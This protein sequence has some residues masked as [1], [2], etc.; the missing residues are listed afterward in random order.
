MVTMELPSK[1]TLVGLWKRIRRIIRQPSDIGLALH[2]GW[3]MWRAP[4]LLRRRNLRTFL[5]ELRELRRPNAPDAQTSRERILRLRALC[6]RLPALRSRANCYIRALTLYRFL[7]TGD[8]PVTIHFGIEENPDPRERL[9]GHAW[10][11]IDGQFFEGPPEAQST[12]I[13]TV[14]LEVIGAS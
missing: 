9:R 12:R 8:R 4:S 13:K 3:F 6:L 14:P 7:D 5:T 10:I 1:R 11:S 2:I